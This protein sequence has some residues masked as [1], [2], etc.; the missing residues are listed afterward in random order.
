MLVGVETSLQAEPS[1]SVL[2]THSLPFMELMGVESKQVLDPSNEAGL[3]KGGGDS[4]F[5]LMVLGVASPL[6]R[7]VPPYSLI[8]LIP[9][10]LMIPESPASE[11]VPNTRLS[12]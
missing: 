6:F 11:S 12:L 3:S 1:V 7:S 5:L 8:S 4:S 9:V 10:L 2:E